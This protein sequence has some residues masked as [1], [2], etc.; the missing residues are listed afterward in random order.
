MIH[1]GETVSIK[2]TIFNWLEVDEEVVIILAG[3]ED[4]DFVNVEQY[5][6]VTSFAPRLSSGEHHH[7]MFVRAG[8]TFDINLPIAPR[9]QHGTLQATVAL[10]R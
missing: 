9:L 3:S 8:E 1:R 2:C 10:S 4:Y 7:L 6:Y 5:G